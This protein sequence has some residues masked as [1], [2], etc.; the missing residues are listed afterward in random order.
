MSAAGTPA[1]PSLEVAPED[2][3]AWRH[4]GVAHTVLD[5][6]EPWETDICRIADSLVLPLGT[7]SQGIDQLPQDK[8][9]VVVCHHGMRSLQAVMWLRSQGFENAVNLRGGI[10]AWARQVEPQ[11]TTY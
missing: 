9:L 5:V 4:A 8:P 2:V 11:M 6:R 7:L 3:A 10:D 1:A